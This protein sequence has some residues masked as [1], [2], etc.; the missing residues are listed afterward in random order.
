MRLVARFKVGDLVVIANERT[1]R[2]FGLSGEVL[3]VMAPSKRHKD[4]P[5]KYV[6]KVMGAGDPWLQTFEE[7][8]LD[9]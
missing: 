9:D 3:Q 4:R 7:D 2:Y 8:E 5:V 1:P 6:V